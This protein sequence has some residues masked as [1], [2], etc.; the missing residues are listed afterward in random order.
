MEF[1]RRHMP[2]KMALRS[3]ADW[4]LDPFN[5]HTIDRFF[6]ETGRTRQGETPFSLR[7]YLAYVDWFQQQSS[8]RP[9]EAR[10]VRARA[11]RGA[12]PHLSRDARHGRDHRRAARRRCRRVLVF[13]PRARGAGGGAA[14]RALES[15]VRGRRHGEL[16]RAAR[17]NRRRTPERV[18]V[19]GVAVRGRRRARG[20]RPQARQPA[21]CRVGV[22]MD[23]AARR[24]HRAGPE[25]VPSSQRE[26]AE[27]VGA[28]AVGRGPP[29]ARAVARA[30]VA[31]R[32]GVTLAECGDLPVGDRQRPCRSRST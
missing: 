32:A 15:R 1:W 28:Q 27:G 11:A 10:V 21:I 23:S 30:A 12:G 18:R 24:A 31:R 14:A 25:L 20:H 8:I 9:I 6:A 7:T 5:V 4:H 13:P 22:G 2:E 16:R 29:Q 19:G 26:R 3:D 17:D